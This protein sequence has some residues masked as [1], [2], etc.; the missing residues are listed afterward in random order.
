[1]PTT[2]EASYPSLCFS[3]KL[4]I[5]NQVGNV[6]IPGYVGFETA[7]D[8]AYV[9]AHNSLYDKGAKI[10]DYELKTV[11]NLCI[12]S[13]P[14]STAVLLYFYY[15]E[16]TTYTLKS[17]DKKFNYCKPLYVKD[18]AGKVVASPNNV[19]FFQLKVNDK[20]VLLNDIKENTFELTLILKNSELI[21]G[22]KT[23]WEANKNFYCAPI[24]AKRGATGTKFQCTI[25]E[26]GAFSPT[27]HE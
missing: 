19:S 11:D 20:I 13:Y 21:V 15:A 1:M 25:I 23:T 4:S 5:P 10:P 22:E 27:L 7:I 6:P 14:N 8:K 12:N 3:A 17:A 24:L 16:D 2:A 9:H 26:R 18:D